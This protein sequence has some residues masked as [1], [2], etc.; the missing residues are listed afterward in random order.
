[1]ST[2][3]IRQLLVNI[4]NFYINS[5]REI[6]N[7]IPIDPTFNVYQKISEIQVEKNFDTFQAITL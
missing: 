3:K 1:M 5:I 6:E 2:Q 4:I 7:F